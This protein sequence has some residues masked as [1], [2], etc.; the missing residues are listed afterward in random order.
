MSNE[1]S[2][3]PGRPRNKTQFDFIAEILDKRVEELRA[4]VHT[5]RE[6]AVCAA[7]EEITKAIKETNQ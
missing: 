7:L 4:E 5:D 2:A 1:A 3:K 6:D